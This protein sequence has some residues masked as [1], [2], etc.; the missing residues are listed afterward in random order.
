MVDSVTIGHTDAED[1]SKLFEIVMPRFGL[2]VWQMDK[3]ECKSSII[4]ALN[5]GYRLMILQL[6]MVTKKRLVKLY[7]NLAF[8]E[9][10]YL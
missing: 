8:L 10:R 3:N 6:L 2:G 1:G 5:Q 9:K 4:H 7:V